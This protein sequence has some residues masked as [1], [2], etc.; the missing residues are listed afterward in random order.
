MQF[1]PSETLQ[2]RTYIGLILAQFLAAFNDQAIHIVAIF[3]A[4]DVLVRY[5]GHLGSWHVDEKA[6]I[7]LV[8]ACF[9]SPFF[10]FSPLAGMLA[11]KYSKRSILVLWKVAEV[12]MM[13]VALVGFLLPHLGAAGLCNPEL[14][15]QWS[16]VLVISVVFLMGTHSAFF[17]PAKYGVMP[18]IL[19]PA[20]LSRGNGFL[21]GTSF[22]AQIIGTACGGLLYWEWKSRVIGEPGREWLIGLLLLVLA[23]IGAA[24]SLLIARMPPAASDRP[25]TWKLWQPLRAN[26]RVL[27]RSR[28]L[29]LAVL[30]IAFFTFI[31]LF[32]RQTLIYDGE[33]DKERQSAKA[34]SQPIAAAQEE[35]DEEDDAPDQ[36]VEI[37]IALPGASD[38][39]KAELKIALLIALVGF[40]IGVG[41]PLA[42]ALSG[43]KL[44]LGLVPI[45][46]VLL[47]AFTGAMAVLINW[48]WPTVVCL[49]LVGVAAGFYIVPLYTLLQHRA[50]KDS[51]GNLVA[52]SNFIN[53]AGG[54]LAVAAF[55]LVTGGLERLLSLN[56]ANK[57]EEQLKLQALIPKSLFVVLSLMIAGMLVLLCRKLPDFFVRSLLWLRSHSRYRLKVIGVQNLPSEGPA[58]LA[59]NCE[60]FE[61]CMQVVTAT[62]RFTR[63]ILLE[64]DAEERPPW[65]LRYLARRTG[66]VALPARGAKPY[67]W[68]K[69]L[70]KAAKSLGQGHL[71]GV[72]VDGLGPSPE[73][74][75]FLG[76]VRSLAPAPILPVYCGNLA[77]GSASAGHAPLIRR[78]Q[79]VIGHALPP[80]A[81]AEEI[82]RAIHLLGEWMHQVHK[83]GAAAL[84]ATIPRAAI[85]LPT[86]TAPD[87]PEHP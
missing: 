42:G 20:V 50:P 32:A 23:V 74:V 60:H 67:D 65:L 55:Y 64:R 15:A 83:D 48:M 35:M 25:L 85:A 70:A 71:L 57:S 75:K 26:L 82:N 54:L 19:Q 77:E 78:V 39:Q 87:R 11:D 52:T 4:G 7:S 2:S 62:D 9:I 36:L 47:I 44:E 13:A 61:S 37:G 58:I 73:M 41:S 34:A 22:V 86:A 46:A 29:A 30:G 81:S 79:V 59:T 24:A 27:L 40:G 5:V 66:L 53:V 76:E 17:V 3:Y 63:F 6:I 12:G 18:E 31:T 1:Q 72:T 16:A 33:T 10:F 51:K 68:D 69:A 43:N 21:E 8:T 38:T 28:P 80:E 14:L 84:S 56:V 45:G 49:I